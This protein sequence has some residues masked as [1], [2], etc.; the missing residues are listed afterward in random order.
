VNS[1]RFRV[2][3]CTFCL[4]SSLHFLKHTKRLYW[5]WHKICSYK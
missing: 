3:H 5:N 2:L 1:K 4:F